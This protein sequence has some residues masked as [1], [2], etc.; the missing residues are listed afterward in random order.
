[1]LAARCADINLPLVPPR[2][3]SPFGQTTASYPDLRRCQRD[4]RTPGAARPGIGGDMMMSLKPGIGMRQAVGAAIVRSASIRASASAGTPRDGRTPTCLEEDGRWG[5]LP[6]T[7]PSRPS[8]GRRL[9]GRGAPNLK[10]QPSNSAAGTT[11]WSHPRASARVRACRSPLSHEGCPCANVP[12]CAAARGC[13]RARTGGAGGGNTQRRP[14]Y[15][16]RSRLQSILRPGPGED[17]PLFRHPGSPP[18][19]GTVPERAMSGGHEGVD[20]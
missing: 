20:T 7:K 3:G 2:S 14:G 17:K 10:S 18:T 11:P 15:R 5:G 12:F 19:R 6:L 8:R 1:M 13:D 16:E 9:R 4:L